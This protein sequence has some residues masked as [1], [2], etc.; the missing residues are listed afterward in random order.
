[1]EYPEFIAR[2]YDVIYSHVRNGTDNEF[3][4]NKAIEAQGKVLEIG[5]GTG[6]LF[7]DALNRGADI[8]GIDI[9]PSMIDV[10][11]GKMEP[12]TRHRVWVEDAVVMNIDMKFELILA[13]FRMLSHVLEIED[14]LKFFNRVADHLTPNGQF[15][16]D[17]YVPD[18]SILLQGIDQY[19][20]FEGE[21]DKG[22]RIQRYVTAKADLI[23]QTTRVTMKLC[24]EEHGEEKTDSWEFAMRFFFRYEIEHLIARS[25]LELKT[26][27]GDYEE[28]ILTKNSRDFVVVCTKNR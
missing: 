6:R 7:L 16:F 10:L 14:Q 26:I 18:L 28:N 27:Y 3:F 4:L 11:H 13:P 1:M 5:V 24:W 8:F 17:L 12:Q 20:D 19:K 23:R 22:Q 2:F 25:N 9:S 21:Y 15:I